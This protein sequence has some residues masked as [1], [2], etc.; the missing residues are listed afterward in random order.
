MA[1]FAK[2]ATAC[3]TALWPAG[4]FARTHEDAIQGIIDADQVAACVREMMAKGSS[5]TG[6]AVDRL[7]AGA[8]RTAFK[9]LGPARTLRA[10][11]A[12]KKKPACRIF[13]TSGL[14][15]LAARGS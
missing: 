2:W 1:D 3:E 8:D 10:P 13:P 15:R 14:A 5:W 7:R 6:S 12:R 9:C 4:T 11:E